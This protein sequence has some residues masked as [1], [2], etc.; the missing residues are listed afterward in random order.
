MVLLHAI[1]RSPFPLPSFWKSA[2][3]FHFCCVVGVATRQQNQTAIVNGCAAF[4]CSTSAR[5]QALLC[6][7]CAGWFLCCFCFARPLPSAFSNTSCTL[8]W[9][10]VNVSSK[11]KNQ[12]ACHFETQYAITFAGSSAIT[13]CRFPARSLQMIFFA[14]TPGFGHQI[15]IPFKIVPRALFVYL[16]NPIQRSIMSI[17]GQHCGMAWWNWLT[18]LG[19]PHSAESLEGGHPI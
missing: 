6:D 15:D 7:R 4:K 11:T 1:A 16:R 12:Q 18:C 19:C 3:S 13:P 9:C 2:S 5:L 17:L 10:I 14:T 8:F